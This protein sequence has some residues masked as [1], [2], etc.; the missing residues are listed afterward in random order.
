[1]HTADQVLGLRD[2]APGAT[3]SDAGDAFGAA[4]ATARMPMLIPDPRR[5]DN[6][7]VH[8]NDA[9]LALTGYAREEVVGR[10]CPF[11]QGRAPDPATVE[12]MSLAMRRGEAVSVEILNYRKDGTPFWNALH[13]SPVR[14]GDGELRY[15]FGSQHDV[16]AEKR[17]EQQIQDANAR[18][19]QEVERRTRD[20]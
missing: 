16:S 7:I 4:F 6:P 1:M 19:E 20:L 5:P 11:L 2:A 14:D 13:V 17:L 18:L 3:R 10:N 15:F 8:A 9:F 12:R